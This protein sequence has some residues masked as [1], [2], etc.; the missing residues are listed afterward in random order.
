MNDL[1]LAKQLCKYGFDYKLNNIFIIGFFLLGILYMYFG[2][3]RLEIAGAIFVML[4]PMYILQT[5]ASVNYTSMALTSGKRKR[6]QL[7]M[8]SKINSVGIYI[9]YTLSVA[10]YVLINRIRGTF[11]MDNL[12]ENIIYFS[13]MAV[14]LTIYSAIAYKAFVFGLVIFFALFLFFTTKFYTMSISTDYPFLIY[15][16]AAFVMISVGNIFYYLITKLIY[17]MP[18]SRLALGARLR[19]KL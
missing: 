13:V 9:S 8:W 7:D 15:I 11:N 16:I 17:K 18:Y 1:K 6:M 10:S 5:L 12:K 3:N 2:K 4:S 19:S 14:I